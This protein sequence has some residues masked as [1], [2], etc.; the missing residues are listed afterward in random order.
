MGVKTGIKYEIPIE[1]FEHRYPWL[2]KRMESFEEVD[3]YSVY[4]NLDDGRTLLYDNFMN[5]LKTVK[6]FDDDSELTEEEWKKGFSNLLAERLKR[7]GINQ[8][9]LARKIGVSTTMVNHYVNGRNIPSVYMLR[10]ISR[11]LECSMDDLYPREYVV[12][13]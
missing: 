9:E 13:D 5:E 8:Y 10:R 4:I 12:L 1:A 7:S 3:R 2:F 6:R 11:V